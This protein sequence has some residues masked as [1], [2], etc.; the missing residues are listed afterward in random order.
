MPQPQLQAVQVNDIVERV[1]ALHEPALKNREHP[2][3]MQLKLDA[4]LPTIAADTDLLH[5]A[6]SNLVLNA[7]DAMPQGGTI[8]ITTT[9]RGRDGA[10]RSGRHRNGA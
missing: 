8:T 4:A 10:D 1:A 9:S 3:D 5:R 6:L 7:M 2:V